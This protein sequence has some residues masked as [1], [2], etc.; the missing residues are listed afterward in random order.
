ML[1]RSAP[2]KADGSLELAARPSLEDLTRELE[3]DRPAAETPPPEPQQPETPAPAPART[4][5]PVP[6]G[7]AKP[8]PARLEPEKTEP[9]EPEPLRLEEPPV[10]SAPA[11]EPEQKPKPE[12]KPKPRPAPAARTGTSNGRASGGLRP[13]RPA[14]SPPPTGTSPTKSRRGGPMRRTKSWKSSK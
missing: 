6:A 14:Q 5:Q 10:Q 8:E 12:P 2:E 7:P 9:A 1:D 11:P 3:A 4:A 13:S